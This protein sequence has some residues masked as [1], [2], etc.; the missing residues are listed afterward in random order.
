MKKCNYC[1]RE[2]ADGAPQCAGCGMAEF[3]APTIG[4]PRRVPTQV[5][6]RLLLAG[7]VGIFVLSLSLL[8]AWHNL[9]PDFSME[10]RYTRSLL[11]RIDREITAQQRTN[12]HPVSAEAIRETLENPSDAW[13]RPLVFSNQGTNLVVLS[14]GRDGKPGGQGLDCDLTSLN[15]RPKESLPTLVQFYTELPT[16][17][18]ITGCA[19]CAA[20]AAATSMLMVKRID[21]TAPALATAAFKLA[22]TII[23]AIFI[24]MTIS[25]LH[26]PSGH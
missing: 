2:N 24:A 21:L 9:Q 15:P 8:V 25:A 12:P 26:V 11:K 19:I 10:Q 3:E 22:A 23:A 1:G 17:G 13:H 20:L 7:L 14:Y 4:T 16:G 5:S 6:A 18:V